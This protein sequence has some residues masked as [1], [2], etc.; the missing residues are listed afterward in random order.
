M[1]KFSEE[2]INNIIK[3]YKEGASQKEIADLY[4]TYNTS[5][6]RVLIRKNIKIRG[7]ASSQAYVKKNPFKRNDEKSDYFLGLLLTDGCISN[8]KISLSLKEEDIYI[9]KEFAKFCSPKLQ[10]TKYYHSIHGEFQYSVHFKDSRRIV[11]GY[12]ERLGRFTNKSY[13]CKLYRPIN[14]NILRGIID[15][16]GSIYS[17]NQ[18]KSLRASICSKS[19]DFIDQITYFYQKEGYNYS[20]YQRKDGLYYV[21]IDSKKDLL[22]LGYNL[23]H[24]ARIFL[25]RKYERWSHFAEMHRTNNTLNSGN[26]MAI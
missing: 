10:V 9:L 1:S 16:D 2:K 24:N 12:L 21:N 13:E 4:N 3:L 22:R 6:R 5:I 8:S 25:K 20:V 26:E 14:Y 23:Y 7:E 11:I 15:G 17:T 19:K 18:G